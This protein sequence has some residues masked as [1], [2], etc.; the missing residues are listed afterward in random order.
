MG[1]AV[2]DKVKKDAVGVCSGLESQQRE[3]ILFLTSKQTYFTS[4]TPLNI[5]FPSIS[6]S[7]LVTEQLQSTVAV[8]TDI[9]LD[10]FTSNIPTVVTLIP[11]DPF[12][13]SGL[14]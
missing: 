10:Y 14:A 3:E 4:P 12:S 13:S 8:K 6:A 9:C 7:S 5:I 11:F 1:A 2:G